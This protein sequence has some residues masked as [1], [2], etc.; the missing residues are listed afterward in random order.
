MY[1]FLAA[2]L[3]LLSL[4]APPE[5]SPEAFLDGCRQ[6][7][8]KRHFEAVRQVMEGRLEEADHPLLQE[9]RNRETQLRNTLVRVRAGRLDRDPKPFL[10]EQAGADP[11]VD[12]TVADAYPRGNPLERE[13]A[14]DRLRWNQA[15]AEA[16][17]DPFTGRA[18]L[19]Y[20]LKLRLAAR[21]AAF[22]DEEGRRKLEALVEHEPGNDRTGEANR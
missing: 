16:G 2:S 17:Y 19:A 7:L 9:W 4:D 14:L 8:S 10:R 3:P 18:M 5:I 21:W 1:Y 22:S 11:A 12:K 13:K 6:H 15:E 20:A